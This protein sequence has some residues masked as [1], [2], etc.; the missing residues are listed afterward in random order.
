M[1]RRCSSWPTDSHC[2]PLPFS[3]ALALGIMYACMHV[4]LIVCVYMRVRIYEYVCVC[5]FLYASNEYEYVCVCMCAACMCACMHVCIFY[6]CMHVCMY[7]CATSPLQVGNYNNLSGNRQK[8]EQS[9][10]I[11]MGMG[12]FPNG[13]AG[14][15]SAESKR[16]SELSW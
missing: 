7:I 1:R 3:V 2:L 10:E 8:R 14:G 11:K 16:R 5:M 6:A 12:R 13:S 9:M 15:A 4:C